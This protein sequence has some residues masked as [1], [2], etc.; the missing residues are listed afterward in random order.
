[1]NE[2]IP[3]AAEERPRPFHLE[4]VLPTLVRPRQTFGRIAAQSGGIWLTAILLL[5]LTTI[6]RVMVAGAIRLVNPAGAQITPPPD[7]QYWSPEQQAQFMQA[8]Q[9]T[10]S[11]V[12]VFVFP[13]LGGVLGV[14]IGWLIVS[15]LIHLVLTLQGGRASMQATANIVAWAALPFALRDLVRAAAM[16]VSGRPITHAGLSGFIA[17]DAT[18]LTLFTAQLLALVDLY[19]IWHAALIVTGV[20]AGDG[21][22]SRVRTWVSVGVTL[23][24]VLAAQ[25]FLGYLGAQ[26]SNM[27]I[28]R[29]F[30]F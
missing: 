29:P 4:W 16:L 11:P 7:F 28:M 3:L 26:I 24:V 20:R 5:S 25:A 1:M 27:T 14:W 22:L 6:L 21:G 9:A 15:G 12:F 17:A 23:L 13:A 18:G 30:F 10:N 8:M 19:L 2:T